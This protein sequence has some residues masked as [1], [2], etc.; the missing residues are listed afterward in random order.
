MIWSHRCSSIRS[1]PQLQDANV[2][3]SSSP[4]PT[5]LHEDVSSYT[6]IREE[7]SIYIRSPFWT[8]I[9]QV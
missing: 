8:Q 3:T 5:A 2:D 1:Q 4:W 9:I 7:R 6:R